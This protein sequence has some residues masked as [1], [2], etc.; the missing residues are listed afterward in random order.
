[1]SALAK[2]PDISVYA[3]D[4][5]ANVVPWDCWALYNNTLATS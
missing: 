1:M 3:R 4:S 5:L 2:Q